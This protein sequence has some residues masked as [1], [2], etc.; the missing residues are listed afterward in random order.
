[1]DTQQA[2]LL[3]SMNIVVDTALDNIEFNGIETEDAWNT[4]CDY[5]ARRVE[6][7]AELA[8]T[9]STLLTDNG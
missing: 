4:W 5:H 9:A 7:D 2:I 3:D 8:A 1:M 6:A